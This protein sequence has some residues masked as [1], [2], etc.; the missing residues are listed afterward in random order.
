MVKKLKELAEDKELAN[1]VRSSA[2]Q[3]WQAGLGAFAKAQEEGGRVFSKLVKEGTQ[4]QQRAEDKV[5]DV[6]DSVGK[7]AD[8][9]GKHASGSWDK[10]EQV[11][12]ERVARALATIGVPTQ[13]DI[14][15]LHAK[16][17]ALSAQV[18]A[19]SQPAAKAVLTPAQPVAARAAKAAPKATAK[20]TTKPTAKATTKPTAKPT[21]KATAPKAAA[22]PA[23]KAAAAKAPARPAATGAAKPAS[24]S[25]AR[26]A[27]KKKAPAL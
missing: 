1:A 4:F 26:P 10:L 25:A 6:S 11:F 3:I 5:A 9:V 7:L 8:G 24:K 20:P 23:G 16:L 27:A 2:Q 17:D 19:L 22:K 18:A 14:V 13:H 12:E 21:T 15:A